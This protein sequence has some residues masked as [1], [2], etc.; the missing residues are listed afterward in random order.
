MGRPVE[1]RLGEPITAEELA[2]LDRSTVANTL[3]RRT[4]ALA[5]PALPDPDEVFHW[6]AHIRW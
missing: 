6:P 2:P 1:I 4:M 3:R 5:G